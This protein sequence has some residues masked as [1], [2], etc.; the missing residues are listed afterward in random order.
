MKININ[1]D[2]R[3]TETEIT[4][5]CGQM[6][7]ELEKVIATLRIMDLKLKITGSKNNQVY[8]LE[9]PKILYIDTVDK[10]TFLYTKTDIY[11]TNLKLYRL[12]ELLSSSD[13]FRASKS[14]IINFNCI[15]SLR[16]DIAGRIIVTMENDEKLVVSRQY[17]SFIKKKL[18]VL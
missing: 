14:C 13:F 12:E 17:S 18:G 15:K 10:R 6:S 9:A 4:I 7:E 2:N 5:N 11:E 1:I 3:F 8:I 16:S